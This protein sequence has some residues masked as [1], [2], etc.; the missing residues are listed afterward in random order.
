MP[1]K[2]KIYLFTLERVQVGGGAEV[3]GEREAQADC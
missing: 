2:K 1:F 3:E